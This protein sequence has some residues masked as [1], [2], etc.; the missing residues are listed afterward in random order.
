[1]KY[2]Y[3]RDAGVI[4][5]KTS[6]PY[7]Y[8]D[9]FFTRLDNAIKLTKKFKIH[10]QLTIGKDFFLD[11]LENFNKIKAKLKNIKFITV[12][13]QANYNSLISNDK[14]SVL[15][16]KKLIS[17]SNELKNIVGYCVHPDHVKKYDTLKKLKNKTNYLAIE[18]TDLKARSGNN[19]KQIQKLL[20]RYQYLNLV[21]D[22]SHINDIKSKYK[23]EPNFIEYC[24]F[25]RKRIVEIQISSNENN[26]KKNIFTEDFK[27]DHSLLAISSKNIAVNLLKMPYFKNLNLV[28]E[29]VVP[30]SLYGSRLL[31]KEIS[32]LKKIIK[33]N[34][35]E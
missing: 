34:R 32:I 8:K 18:V 4:N 1:M 5:E 16:I 3:L 23:N 14:K 13:L 10:L 19:F 15:F 21:L 7:F 28:I 2:I 12:H 24:N 11:N 33:K 35:I 17:F 25:F 27:T 30:Y 26:Y 31:S 9:E 6:N 29:G 20:N 22:T